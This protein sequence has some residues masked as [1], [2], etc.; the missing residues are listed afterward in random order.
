MGENPL[1]VGIVGANAERGW[2][3]EAHIPALAKLPRFKVAAV[4]SRLPE[5]AEAAGKAWGA[6]SVYNDSLEL[7]ESP[8]IDIATITVRVPQHFDIVTAALD[9]GKHVF[10]EWP[11]GR[12]VKEAEIMT[13]KEAES[14]G[15]SI[16]GLQGI[17]SPTIRRAAEVVRSGALGRVLSARLLAPS[18]GWAPITVPSYVYLND[19]ENGATLTTIGAGH[20]IGMLV[21]VL[22]RITEVQARGTI[23]HPKVKVVGTDR[24]VDRNCFDHLTFIGVHENGCVTSLESTS[25]RPMD[26]EFLFDITGASGEL[27]IKGAAGGGFQTANL[28]LEGTIDFDAPAPFVTDVPQPGANLAEMYAMLADEIDGKPTEAPDF[29]E[30]LDLHRLLATIDH[31]SDTGQRERVAY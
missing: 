12:T 21:R 30:A 22:G 23:Q 10:C 1:R 11:L 8:E 20:A 6:E 19:K 4:S 28:T 18:A 29:A 3:R 26:S 5:V 25:S 14:K 24:F 17:G 9:A 13:A 2:A 15:V 27:R 16:I 31:A 7:V